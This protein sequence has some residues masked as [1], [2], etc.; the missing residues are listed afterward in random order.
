M[1]YKNKSK[2]NNSFRDFSRKIKEGTPGDVIF[3]YGEEE[4]LIDWAVSEIVN[5]YVNKASMVL[6]YDKPDE[7]V[8]AVEDI[9]SSAETLPML[10]EKRVIWVKDYLPLYKRSSGFGEREVKIIK[11][12]IGKPNGNAILIFSAA[13][14]NP[15]KRSRGEKPTELAE[16]LLNEAQA[17]NFCHL[18]AP[19]LKGFINKRLQAAGKTISPP[20]L[21]YLIDISGYNNKDSEYHLLNLESD[22]KKITALSPGEAITEEEVSTAVLGDMDRYVFDFLDRVSAGKKDEAYRLMFNMIKSG[23]DV[24]E[25]LANLVNQFELMTEV[26]EL[27]ESGYGL[28]EITKEMGIHEFRIKKALGAAEKFSLDKLKTL[29]CQLY[30]MDSDIKKGDI[31]G[32]VAL[33]LLIGRI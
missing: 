13:M 32:N 20:V 6:D 12:Y 3:L 22:L 29:L 2:S 19:A 5:R 21:K 16:L 27:R 7:D 30:D 18:D 28:P 15:E 8:L 1:A 26:K 23:S 31:Q 17:Y 11:N 10:S 24:F 33:E 14:L 4:L 9:I 25:I